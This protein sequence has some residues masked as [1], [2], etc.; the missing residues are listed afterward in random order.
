M[1]FPRGPTCYLVKEAMPL[2][3]QRRASLPIV[4]TLAG[5]IVSTQIEATYA[6]PKDVSR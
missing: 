1:I 5:G 6:A 2:Y 4:K 3:L